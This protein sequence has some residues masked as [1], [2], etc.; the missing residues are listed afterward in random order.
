MVGNKVLAIDIETFCKV[1][2][3]DVGVYRYADDPSFEVLLFAYA[4]DDEEVQ[5]IDLAQGE[6]IPQQVID[7]IFDP[8]VSKAAFNAQFERVCLSRH[9]GTILDPEGWHCTMV[10]ALTLGLSGSLD[11]VAR[12]IN[13]P[14]DKQKL[15]T[16]KNLIRLFSVPRKRT[17]T[18]ANQL[19]L[20]KNKVTDGLYRYLPE[21]KPEEWKQFKDYCIQDVVVERE[22]RKRLMAYPLPETEKNLYYLD[23]RINDYGVRL[24]ME[25]VDK[26]I[27]IDTIYTDRLHNAFVELTKVENPK[28]VAQFKD[29][30]SHMLGFGVKSVT[31]NSIPRLLEEAENQGISEVSEALR[32]RQEI[33]KTSVSKYAKMNEVIN[34]DGRARGLLQFYGANRTGRWAGRLV[35]IQNLPRNRM[36][37]EELEL[38]RSVVKD[39]DLETLEL[40]YDNIPDIL[41]QLIRTAF[42]PSE[43]HRFIVSDFS[44]IEARVIA[45]YA[46]ET[47]RL[48]VFRSHGKIY[49]ASAAAMFDVPIE[50]ISRDSP[51][52]Q[53]GKIAE[54]ALGYQGGVGALKQMGALDMGL[55]EDELPELVSQWRHANP[56]IVQFWKD[57][58]SA[59]KQAILDKTTVTI[60][61]GPVFIYEPGVLFIKLASG[62]RLAYPNPRVE[63]HH[64]FQGTKITFDGAGVNRQWGRI[65]TYGGKLVENIVQATARD[66]LTEALIK[67]DN[68]GY[69][70]AFHVHDEVVLDVPE[71]Y[72][73][74]EEVN[75]LLS[76]DIPWAPGLPM[77]ADSFECRFYQKD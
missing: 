74:I 13:L 43:G 45:W 27:E 44:A 49:E 76:E 10:H 64:T 72:G 15:W 63:P 14:Q 23:Q 9:F 5:I 71:G 12:A 73:S 6:K 31:K 66:C 29:W 30:L 56:A 68:A 11:Q 25:F 46:K 18:N 33:S 37:R 53:K 75:A 54:L 17:K 55:T 32:L 38:A 47:W 26:A 51:L 4:F 65:D 16:G 36:G 7:A 19:S 50:S 3:P 41:S 20:S 42:I 70:I 1:S 59:A 61:Q 52:R 22:L 62:R 77:R 48:D 67:L 60:P 69:K 40:L 8:S 2:L 21:D 39:G 34:S 28:S 57:A 35:Q 24:D 58:G